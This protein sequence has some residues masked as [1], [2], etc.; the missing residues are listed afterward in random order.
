M[1]TW[2]Y[3]LF[4]SAKRRIGYFIAILLRKQAVPG[5]ELPPL[6]GMRLCESGV[7]NIQNG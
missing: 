6:D 3:K 7:G 1:G 2:A 5:R 4:V